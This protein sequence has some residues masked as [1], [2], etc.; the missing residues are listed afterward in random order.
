MAGGVQVLTHKFDP[1]RELRE[2]GAPF[3]GGKTLIAHGGVSAV[4]VEHLNDREIVSAQIGGVFP[5]P[6]C[7]VAQIAGRIYD[8]LFAIYRMAVPGKVDVLFV[9]DIR[10]HVKL[11]GFVKKIVPQHIAAARIVRADEWIEN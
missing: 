6:R 4:G 8:E 5:V 1:A 3:V 7:D 11:L 10:P 9:A 2:N